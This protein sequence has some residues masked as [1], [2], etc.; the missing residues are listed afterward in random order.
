MAAPLPP[1]RDRDLPVGTRRILHLDVDAFLASVE[2][3]LHPQLAGKP[4][5]VGG[6]PRSRNLVMSCSYEARR[7]GIRPGLLLRD[8]QRRCPRAI[9]RDGDSQAANRLREE[10]TRILLAFTPRVEVASI[11]DFFL[12]L[13]GTQRLH[14]AAF[15]TALHIQKLVREHCS[16]PLTIGVGTNRITARLAGK[17]G[18]PGG[19][20]EILPGYERT[21][22]ASLPVDHLPGVG[23]SIGARLERFSIRTVGELALI[24]REI[25]FASFG[26]NGLALHERAQGK[27]ESPIEATHFEDEHGRLHARPPRSLQRETTFEPEEGRRIIIEAMLSYLVER[28]AHR[29][30]QLNLAARTLEV[31][32]RWVD[33]R[34]RPQRSAPHKEPFIAER[35]RTLSSPTDA[36]DEIWRRSLRLYRDLPRKRAL[37]KRITLRLSNLTCTEGW[38][39][40]LFDEAREQNPDTGT[41]R[42]DRQ[43]RLD[44]ALDQLR[45][46]HGF[47]R[48]LRGTS[49]PLEKTH[50]LGPDGYRLRTPSL[51]Q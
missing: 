32:I 36:T 50:P 51:N 45:K 47:G 7:F 27:D 31:R 6:S 25:L 30:R 39:G 10:I 1:H 17:L 2:Q 35:R 24:P 5:V 16:L 4:V 8:A 21:F 18:K 42:P 20:A 41:S 33:T 12:D 14:G 26:R 23:H 15:G 11:D 43:R 29:L 13:S 38:Q 9:F 44:S 34:P 40:R 49:T 3:A 28:A 22:L 37:V 46:R 19:V 48:I